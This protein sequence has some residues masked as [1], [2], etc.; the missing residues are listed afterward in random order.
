VRALLISTYDLGRQPFG[1][2]SAAAWLRREGMEVSTADIAKEK[3]DPREAREADL[4]AFF[5]PMHTAT[6]LAAPLVG[7]VRSEN[8]SARICAFGL[9]APLN[10]QLLRELG[11]D[12]VLGGEFEEA[13]AEIARDLQRNAQNVEPRTPHVERSPNR[14]LPRIQFLVPDRTGLPPLTRYATLQ[15]SDGTRRTV[16]YTEAS[17]GCRHLCRHC[18][19]VPIYEGQFRVVQPD[20]VLSDIA[21]QVAAGAQHITFGDPDF[22]NGPTHAVR[23]V[24][25]LHAAWPAVTYDATIKIEHLLQHAQL[26]PRLRDTGCLFVT[27]AVESLDDRVLASLEKGHTRADFLRAIELCRAADLTLVPTFVA[28]HPWTTLE[29]YCELLDTIERVGMIGHVAPIQLAIRLLVPQGSL[30][31]QLED[32][33]QVVGPFDP[34]TMTYR[35]AH[36]DPRVDALHQDVAALVGSRLTTARHQLFDAV[37][38]LAHERASAV[39][40]HAQPR[41]DRATVPYLNEPWYC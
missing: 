30:I 9:Y 14:S 6:R 33:R 22:F 26:L 41:R 16:G 10:A 40:P 36:A 20:V 35:W 31:L 18:P 39:R 11:V 24:E 19:I 8:Q 38:D 29:T 7:R 12:D 25:A 5:L 2:A 15:L 32:V 21:A 1:L 27:S 3:L 37:S 34:H 4:V 17:R 23:I 28:F 13:L